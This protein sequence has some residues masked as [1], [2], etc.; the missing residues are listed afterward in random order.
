M[1]TLWH[2]KAQIA[3]TFI[4]FILIHYF[5]TIFVYLIYKNKALKSGYC[6]NFG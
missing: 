4:S 5:Y 2:S 3:Y 6:D 1:Y